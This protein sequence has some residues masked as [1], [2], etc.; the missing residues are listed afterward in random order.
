M[1]LDVIIPLLVLAICLVPNLLMIWGAW[2]L[3][4]SRRLGNFC[5]V[6]VALSLVAAYLS[7]LMVSDALAIYSLTI[8]IAGAIAAVVAID[9]FLARQ[10]A[11]IKTI[12]VLAF[13]SVLVFCET[14][15]IG[16]MG[17]M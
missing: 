9:Y 5:P 15:I 1:G 13:F 4:I 10:H 17:H 6:V 12:G 16:V 14:I 11:I 7:Y 3:Q 2:K 8:A